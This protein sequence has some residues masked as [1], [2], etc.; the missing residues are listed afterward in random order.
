MPPRLR[1]AAAKAGAA[2][3]AKPK[4]R[5]GVRF[6]R[7]AGG[8]APLAEEDVEEKFNTH[9]EIQ[10]GELPL[11]SWKRGTAILFK[12]DYYHAAVEGCGEVRSLN[13]EEEPYL[14]LNLLG[15]SSES[16]LKWASGGSRVLRGHICGRECGGVIT[17]PDLCHLQ[18]VS[19]LKEDEKPPWWNNLVPAR[20]ELAALRAADLQGDVGEEPP[21]DPQRV[22]EV[23]RKEKDK[24]ERSRDLVD[25][26][27]GEPA[28]GSKEGKIKRV[29]ISFQKDTQL[30][31]GNTGMDPSPKVR[32]QVR[33]QLKKKFKKKKKKKKDSS[34][35]SGSKSTATITSSSTEEGEEQL[36]GQDMKIRR[37][38]RSG[39]GA[40]SASSIVEMQEHLLTA[41]GGTYEVEKGEQPPLALRYFRQALR[42]R[43]SGGAAREA[44]TLAYA[45]DL[46]IQG[47]V[48][49]S[50]DVLVQRFK[51]IELVSQ[52]TSWQIAQRVELLP[53]EQTS[54]TSREETMMAA[55]E[56]NEDYKMRARSQGG[57]WQ[58]TWNDKDPK[59]KGKGKDGKSKDKGKSEVKGDKKGDKTK[60]DDKKK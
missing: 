15:T 54:V 42:P 13:V 14:I 6:R 10:P 9:L 25:K 3:R 55:K 26:G 23:K 16:L 17:A 1:P 49:S 36:F 27:E 24:K 33:K 39:P 38:A 46:L 53:L 45:A 34:E 21:L 47:K 41:G 51:A 8:G 29:K 35:S 28:T 48:A 43:L 12:A 60:V 7:P 44:M 32:S 4:P 40:L 19:K 22:R 56:F 20:D 58:S 57:Y 2:A 30:V 37:M 5:A 18:K 50:L 52:G 31:F 11:T 59:G